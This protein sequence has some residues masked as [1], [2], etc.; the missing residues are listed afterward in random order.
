MERILLLTPSGGGSIP[1]VVKLASCT[2]NQLI[3]GSHASFPVP[4][5]PFPVL[6]TSNII[7][8]ERQIYFTFVV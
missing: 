6:V 8:L 2:A 7:A 5:S 4:R 1:P 3:P